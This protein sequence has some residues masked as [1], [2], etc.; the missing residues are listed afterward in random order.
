MKYFVEFEDNE[1][2]EGIL[3][4]PIHLHTKLVTCDFHQFWIL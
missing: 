2:K 3:T 1:K 4:L